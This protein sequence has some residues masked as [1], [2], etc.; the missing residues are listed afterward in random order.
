M[1]DYDAETGKL[2]LRYASRFAISTQYGEQ[3]HTSALHYYLTN[4]PALFSRPNEWYLDRKAGII[5]YIPEDPEADPDTLEA[6]APVTDAL[7]CVSEP[8]I[9]I[10]NLELMCT[11][12]DYV[13]AK[14]FDNDTHTYRELTEGGYASD[15]QSV[16]WAPGAIRFEGCVRGSVSDCSI[17]GVGVH[18]VEIRPGCRNIRVESNT[19]DDLC[20]GGVKIWGGEAGCAPEQVT[21]D[22]IVRGNTISRCG[23]RYA[24]GCGVLVCHASNIEISD[25]EIH[26]TD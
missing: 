22:C 18:A 6:Y 20:A 10:R 23:R 2:V 14:H 3:E 19:L 21:S 24:A 17:H 9:R 26:D 7:I 5:Y 16:C 8:D 1:E 25:N 13:S 12:G 4:V 11:R 15:I